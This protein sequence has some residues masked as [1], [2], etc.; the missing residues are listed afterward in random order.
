M[1]INSMETVSV[2]SQIRCDRC[3]KEVACGE[4]GFQ[5]LTSIGFTAGYGSVFGDGNRVEIDVCEPCLRD[6]LG[7]W[8]RVKTPAEPPLAAMLNAF[9]AEVHAGDFPSPKVIAQQEAM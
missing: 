7:A 6:T 8:L 9:N 5:E 3:D 4:L 2:V 1:Q